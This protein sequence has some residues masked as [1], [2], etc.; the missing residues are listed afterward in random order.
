M[1][2]TITIKSTFSFLWIFHYNDKRAPSILA[3]LLELKM[4]NI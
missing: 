3:E 1:M 2:I 4:C